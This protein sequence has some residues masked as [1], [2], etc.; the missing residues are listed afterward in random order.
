M[1]RTVS[2]RELR[3]HTADVLRAVQAGEALTLTVNG[4]PVADIVPHR[5]RTD[6]LAAA[7]LLDDLARVPRTP[8][9]PWP[10]IDVTTDDAITGVDAGG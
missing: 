4:R 3:N 2:V 8:G 6:R 10:G 9:E 5:P 1:Y 7:Q